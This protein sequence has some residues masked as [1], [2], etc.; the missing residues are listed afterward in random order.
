[1]R[2]RFPP[3]VGPAPPFFSSMSQRSAVPVRACGF[4]FLFRRSRSPSYPCERSFLLFLDTSHRLSSAFFNARPPPARAA[5]HFFTS[6]AV[7]P[8]VRQRSFPPFRAFPSVRTSH[9][10]P[11]LL[12]GSLPRY[13]AC[14]CSKNIYPLLTHL[15]FFLSL[16]CSP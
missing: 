5:R 12:A 11:L 4:P 1:M 2:A 6:N 9:P 15:F 7:D 10:T 16:I 3:V 14:V 8:V 13:S